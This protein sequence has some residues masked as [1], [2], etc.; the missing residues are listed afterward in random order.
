[1][2]ESPKSTSSRNDEKLESVFRILIASLSQSVFVGMKT[3]IN[4]YVPRVLDEDKESQS[5]STAIDTISN[6]H[7]AG[8][9]DNIIY[10]ICS[11]G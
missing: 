8:V 7:Q 5:V 10:T 11:L 6:P 2:R 3:L 4:S 1:M 9:L